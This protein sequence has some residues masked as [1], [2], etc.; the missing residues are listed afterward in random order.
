MS[1]RN[2]CSYTR[3]G[4]TIVWESTWD[5]NGE[6]IE[7]ETPVEPYLYYEDVNFKDSKDKSIFG[8]PL[9]FLQFQNTYERNEWIKSSKNIPL[10]EKFTPEKQYLLD[11]YYGM[12]QTPEF[13]KDDLKVYF[14]DI[15]VE[16]SN[17]FPDPEFADYPINVLSIF[18]SISKNMFVWT[19]N[20]DIEKLLTDN[21]IRKIQEEIK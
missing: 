18:D 13:V 9:R 6:R 21:Q 5:K 10:F 11:K 15:E 1:Y 16:I 3:Q 7:I 17:K 12:E 14:F 19:Y 4:K 8:K 20:K 2:I